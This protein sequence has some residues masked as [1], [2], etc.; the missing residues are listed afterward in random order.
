MEP[1][2]NSKSSQG[3]VRHHPL[4][5]LLSLLLRI[6]TAAATLIAVIVMVKSTQTVVT[7]AGPYTAKWRHVPG[8]IWFV[9][10]NSVVLVYS[11]L[12]ALAAGLSVCTRRGPLSYRASAW[13]T[14]FV[15]FVAQGVLI[16]AVSVGL[17]VAL[18]AKHGLPT[19]Q[20]GAVC[21]TVNTFCDYVTGAV[22]ASL[23]A[24]ILQALSLVVTVSALHH[25]ASHK[26]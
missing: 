13:L 24:Y 7:A 18:L 2:S 10:A 23:I 20:W 6:L 26:L 14:F 5:N 4:H 25:L 19:A 8:F 12:G 15:D 11:V 16:S 22:V 9:V 1:V 3:P 17:A 21:S